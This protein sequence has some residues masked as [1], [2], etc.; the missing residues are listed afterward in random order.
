MEIILLRHS[1]TAGNSENRFNGLTDDPLSEEGVILARRQAGKMPEP[2]HIY[3][4]PKT[5]C[6]QTADI[7]WPQ[8]PKTTV[9]DL[10]EMSFGPFEG[11]NHTDLAGSSPYDEWAL[12]GG[13]LRVDGVETVE[14]CRLRMQRALA[15]VL[16]EAEAQGLERIAIVSH[17]GALA[18]LLW[19]AGRPEREG[20]YDWMPRN[21]MGFLAQALAAPLRL[22][23][24][25][26]I[27]EEA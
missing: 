17:G 21:C 24:I 1:T 18:S 2:Q 4:S 23:I 15:F 25:A 7:L 27:G 6:R 3:M 14:E 20:F 8:T 19:E 12:S 26:E 13:A 11:K 10:T 9:N 16:G 5:R 22:Q